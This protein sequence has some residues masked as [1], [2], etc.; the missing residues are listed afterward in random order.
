MKDKGAIGIKW[1]NFLYGFFVFQCVMRVISTVLIIGQAVLSKIYYNFRGPDDVEY[2]AIF[3]NIIIFI[4]KVFACERKYTESGYTLI[5]ASLLFDG[6]FGA[7]SGFF[8]GAY[9]GLFM[10][11]IE[12]A[13]IIP[14][15]IYVSKRKSLYIG[16][17]ENTQH[18]ASNSVPVCC[19]LGSK[20]AS[21]P[22]CNAVKSNDISSI[23][24]VNVA[25]P[26]AMFCRK[27]GAKLFE[28]GNFCPKCGT[29]VEDVKNEV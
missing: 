3:M 19:D 6:I 15:I 8:Q 24:E 29:R 2:F 27:C 28:K 9:T 25:F 1:L 4:I 23:H 7:L 18:S 22:V 14:N 21:I 16:G 13:I 20:E 12:M 11:L 26:K 10:L 5:N 17:T